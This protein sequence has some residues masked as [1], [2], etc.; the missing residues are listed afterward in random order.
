[1]PTLTAMDAQR[2]FLKLI[3]DSR[4]KHDVYHIHHEQG[5]VVLLSE[6]DYE[7]LLE[8]LDLLAIP[9]FQE[10]LQRSIHQMKGGETISFDE[11]FGEPQ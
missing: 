6:E 11:V 3:Q 9:G 1:M 4:K 8:T 2:D 10:S 5:D 7:N